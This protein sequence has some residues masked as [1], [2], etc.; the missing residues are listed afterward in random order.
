VAR[1]QWP[2]DSGQ[3]TVA[4]GEGKVNRRKVFSVQ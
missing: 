3:G 1:G 4:C 2:G